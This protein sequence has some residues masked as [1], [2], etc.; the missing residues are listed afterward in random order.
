MKPTLRQ[1]EYFVAVA[2]TGQVMRAAERCSASQSSL[3]IALQNLEVIVGTPLFVRHAKG[4]RPTEAGERFLRHAYRILNA[5]D[6]AL[7]EARTLPDDAGGRLRL[8][9]TETI[10]AYLLPSVASTLS[11][12]FP[13]VE[14][15]LI[16]GDRRE[17]EMAVL[18]G[19]V[20]LALLLVSNVVADG[21]VSHTLLRS[22]RRLWTNPGHPLLDKP[23]VT[24]DDVRGQRF[25]LLDMDE[26]VQ[27]VE[28]YWHA[29]HVEPVVHFRTRS[30][31]SIRS[32]VAQGYGVSI[33]SDLVYR[34][35]SI[36]G[37]RI[38]RRDLGTGVP[39]MDV[40][41][42]WAERRPPQGLTE[43]IVG[44]LRTLIREINDRGHM[45]VE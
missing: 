27:T 23:T 12:R 14:L 9:V 44:A 28:R 42:V 31:E 15:T 13:N 43:R 32:M 16:E 22:T 6:D 1:I 29:A 5:T 20:D 3:T 8:A 2:E 37:G 40:G 17:L 36:D 33:L 4:L 25:L 38:L 35:W 41:L 30:I 11:K 10:S 24:L 7:H 19:D 45:G 34:P 39:S 26:H 21:L 18:A